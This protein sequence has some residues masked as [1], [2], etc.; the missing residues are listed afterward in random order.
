MK[1]EEDCGEADANAAEEDT[2]GD[3]E[4]SRI[5]CNELRL[6]KQLNSKKPKVA[7]LPTEMNDRTRRQQNADMEHDQDYNG[8]VEPL[9]QIRY[10]RVGDLRL[11]SQARVC[12]SFARD[13][14]RLPQLGRDCFRLALGLSAPAAWPAHPLM[15]TSLLEKSFRVC[16]S[17]RTK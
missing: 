2:D 3:E 4:H 8:A 12:D 6:L 9:R 1:G 13:A 11:L 17:T 15:Q 10:D 14:H 7:L 16:Q 5:R